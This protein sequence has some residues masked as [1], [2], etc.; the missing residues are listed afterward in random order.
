MQNLVWNRHKDHHAEKTRT[1]P[2][3]MKMCIQMIYDTEQLNCK[4][5]REFPT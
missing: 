2:K 4:Q 1:V 5:K 3:L